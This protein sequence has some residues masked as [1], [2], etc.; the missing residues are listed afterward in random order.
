MRTVCGGAANYATAEAESKSRAPD[1]NR[2]LIASGRNCR[3]GCCTCWKGGRALVATWAGNSEDSKRQQSFIL[4]SFSCGP[5][6]LFFF[7]FTSVCTLGGAFPYGSG[8]VC[9]TLCL[10]RSKFRSVLIAI[11]SWHFLK[12]FG[13]SPLC[14]LKCLALPSSL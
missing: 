4:K 10:V 12:G 8:P 2:C 13:A 1:E 5:C 7:F 11:S 9:R 6:W 14:S 3:K